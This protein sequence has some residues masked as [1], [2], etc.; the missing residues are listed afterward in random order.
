MKEVSVHSFLANLPILRAYL[1]N[2]VPYHVGS[3]WG[4]RLG[5]QVLRTT[6]QYL[7]FKVRSRPAAKDISECVNK[8]EEDGV[9]LVENFLN[10]SQFERVRAEFESAFEGIELQPYK[11]GGNARLYRTQISLSEL[12]RNGS[13]ISEYFQQNDTLNRIASAAVRRKISRPP[14]V[15]LDWY[16]SG[17][18]AATDND[19]ENILH[20]DLHTATVKMFFYLDD[21]NESNGAFTYAKRSHHLTLNRLRHEYEFSVRQAKLK[22]GIPPDKALVEVRGNEFRNIID[23]KNRQIM[24]VKETQICVKGNT[25][26]IA[27]N[28]GFHRRGEF[29][30]ERPRKSIQINYRY[31]EKPFGKYFFLRNGR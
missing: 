23:P 12:E 19:I 1:H 18:A 3:V 15:H 4:N 26:V 29:P 31:L 17:D 5:L 16:Q 21:V 9:A 7:Q 6:S 28:M 22:K 10:P 24:N 27:N 11:N 25:L 2:S 30:S 8:V 20:A 14:D 13:T